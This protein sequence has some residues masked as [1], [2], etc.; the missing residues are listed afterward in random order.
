MESSGAN[1]RQSTSGQS[2]VVDYYDQLAKRY[3][4]ERFENSYGSYVDAQER[5][6]LRRWL[7]PLTTGSILDLAC[8][9]G[10]LL[11]MAT[12]GLD[13]SDAMVRIARQKHPC[14]QVYCGPAGELAELG[15][16][17]DAIFCLHLFM[18]LSHAEI[19]TVLRFC[20]D[21][22]RPGGLLVFDLPSA[23]RRKLTM[24]RP[25]GWHAGTALTHGE[26]ATLTAHH[27]RWRATRG[28]L[29]FP[30][31][32]VPKGFRPLLR[33][34]DDL[35]GVTPLKHVSSYVIFCLEKRL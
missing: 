5:R 23:L 35:I 16:R 17:F 29:F 24:F 7:A 4:H 2:Q 13:A 10:R 22:L 20:H 14:K 28:I 21:G 3:D 9:T 6:L 26:I 15:I 34:C 25:A 32:R 1:A 19:E 11:D 30:I 8:G 12:H 18:H 27:W 33:R 31:H